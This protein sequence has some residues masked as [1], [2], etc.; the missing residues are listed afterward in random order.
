MEK[1]QRSNTLKKKYGPNPNKS[2]EKIVNESKHLLYYEVFELATN[3]ETTRRH[4][5]MQKTGIIIPPRPLNAFMLYR[6]NLMASH[7]FKNRSP[8]ERKAKYLSKEIAERW[9]NEDDKT[10]VVF[11]AL[12]RIAEKRHKEIYKNYKFIRKFKDQRKNQNVEEPVVQYIPSNLVQ[13]SDFI[14]SLDLVRDDPNLLGQLLF[15]DHIY[16]LPN[17]NL[18][19]ELTNTSQIYGGIGLANVPQQSYDELS[20]RSYDSHEL[21]SISQQSYNG[22][23]FPKPTNVNFELT[24]IPQQSYDEL[25]FQSY[26]SHEL[27]SISQSYNGLNSPKPTNVNFELT[28]IPQQPYDELSFRSYDS[29]ELESISQQSYNGLNSS[30]PTSVNFE[31]TNALQQQYSEFSY[32]FQPYDHFK[33]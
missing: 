25:S 16:I 20:F 7:E 22:I 6:R 29:Q 12:A 10:K 8:N 17:P 26:D 23:N 5:N 19:F 18:S 15:G 13:N 3:S 14:S 31:L 33:L 28:N 30:K 32:T 2:D 9:N 21:E 24:N 1:P 27:E 4:E 11:Y